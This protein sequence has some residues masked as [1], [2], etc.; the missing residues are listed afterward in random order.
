MNNSRC[1]VCGGD[2]LDV[3][4]AGPPTVLRCRQCRLARLAEFPDDASRKSFYQDEYYDEASGE[5]FLGPLEAIVRGFR[6]FRVRD[7][8]R[9]LPSAT[10][11][12]QNSVLDVGCGRGLLLERFQQNG[13]RVAGTQVSETA[14]RAC[15]RRLGQPIGSGE[16]PDLDFEAGAFRAVTF[17]HVLEHLVRPFDYLREAHRLLRD[18]GLLVVEVPNAAAPGFRVLGSRDFAFDYPHHLYFFDEVTL[19]GIVDRAGFDVV[20]V[21]RFSLEYAPF[22]TLQNLLNLLPGEP[23]R[24]YRA[25]MTNRGGR[26]I[27]RSPLTLVHGVLAAALAGPALALA[28]ASLALPIGNTL[29][30]YCRKRQPVKSAGHRPATTTDRVAVE[31]EVEVV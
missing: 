29:R 18:D 24:L 20:D 16:L 7:I 28:L 1:H 12:R 5:R 21:S 31:A 10:S 25:L 13:W 30:V 9:H 22:T 11:S 3:L 23:N 6:N 4:L 14:R 26:S 2:V 17:Y 15:E 27:R 8:V 19:R